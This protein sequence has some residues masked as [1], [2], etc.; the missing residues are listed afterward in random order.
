MLGRENVGWPPKGI[1]FASATFSWW[2]VSDDLSALSSSNHFGL[3]A[4]GAHGDVFWWHAKLTGEEYR[5]WQG[6][7]T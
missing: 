4:L 3:G 5:T 6:D 2:S 7:E 1:G